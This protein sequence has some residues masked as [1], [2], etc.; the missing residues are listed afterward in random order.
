MTSG[1]EM[2][3]LLEQQ[4]SAMRHSTGTSSS[5]IRLRT[6]GSLGLSLQRPCAAVPN[7]TAGSDQEKIGCFTEEAHE[8]KNKTS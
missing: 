5:S 3:H 2:A 8:T 1:K 7:Q 4:S 6:Q